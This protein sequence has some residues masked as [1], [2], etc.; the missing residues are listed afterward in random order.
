MTCYGYWINGSGNPSL[1]LNLN[2]GMDYPYY[3]YVDHIWAFS[4]KPTTSLAD[5]FE[6]IVFSAGDTRINIIAP[7]PTAMSTAPLS[8]QSTAPSTPSPQSLSIGAIIG[9]IVGILGGIAYNTY[10]LI[11][12]MSK[13]VLQNHIRSTRKGRCPMFIKMQKYSMHTQR[14]ILYH[15]FDRQHKPDAFHVI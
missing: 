14:L 11:F 15:S 5:M 12:S 9:I 13:H 3:V 7:N 2:P 10:K 8:S 1:K 4:N 6:Y